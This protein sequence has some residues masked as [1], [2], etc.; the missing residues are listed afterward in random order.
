MS[1]LEIVTWC[2]DALFLI[3]L[4]GLMALACSFIALAVLHYRHRAHGMAEEAAL[5]ETALPED[6]PRVLIQVPCYNEGK[7]IE[8]FGAAAESNA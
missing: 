5:M 7:L 6:L 1:A 4:A 3:A 8:Q 2:V